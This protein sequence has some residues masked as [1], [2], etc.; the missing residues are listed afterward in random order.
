MYNQNKEKDKQ[1]VEWTLRTQT[2]KVQK[3]I[4]NKIKQK[5]F[6]ICFVLCYYNY[7]TKQKENKLEEI[8]NVK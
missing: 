1:H 4:Y 8:K 6:D 2:G 7:R 5:V 3:F